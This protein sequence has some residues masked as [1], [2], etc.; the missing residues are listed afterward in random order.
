M[1]NL[2]TQLPYSRCLLVMLLVLGCCES[3]LETRAV[4][5]AP[6]GAYPNGNTAEGSGALF[7]LTN[8]FWNTALGQQALYHDTSGGGNTAVGVG[9]LFKNSTA[10]A[11][12]ATG[13]DALFSNTTGSYS[14]AD[15]YQALANAVSG[16]RNTAVGAFALYSH[17]L[18]NYNNAVGAFALHSDTT[19]TTNNAFG[20]G[21]LG[22]NTSGANNTALGDDALWKNTTGNLNTALGTL[23]GG[24]LTTGNNNIDIG[25]AGLAGESNTIRVGGDIGSGF[26]TQTRTFIAGIRGVRTANANTIP[27]VIDSAGQLGTTSSSGRSKKEIK[28]MD[29]ASEAI[30]ALK[31]VV[32]HYKGDNT[33][34]PQFGLI[35]EEVAEI[36]PDLVVRDDNGELYTVR[37]DAVNAMLLNE[38]LKEHRKVQK[39][40]REMVDQRKE[41]GAAAQEHEKEIKV[42]TAVVK[43]QALQIRKVSAQLGMRNPEPQTVLNNQP[44]GAVHPNRLGD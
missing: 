2:V 22:K 19:G 11:N 34:T 41:F 31:P 15:G 4:S 37:Y 1:R 39:L 30:L 5:P 9:A 8:G 26:G 27:V 13:L 36:N 23:A 40:E 6:D 32:F 7:S 14:T 38:F 24:N 33:N 35:A 18:G 20:D 21:A 17:T 42:L 29:R 25:N 44:V 10:S 3:P 28:P 43:E 16:S 12:T